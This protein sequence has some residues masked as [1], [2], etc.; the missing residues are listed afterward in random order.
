MPKC[1]IILKDKK[2][3]PPPAALTEPH[4]RKETAMHWNTALSP[5]DKPREG[6]VYAVVEAFGKIF[7]LRYGYYDDKD[8]TGPPDVIYPDFLK[9]PSY[10]ESG[11]PLVTRMQDACPSYKGEARRADDAVCPLWI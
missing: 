3:H 1:D 8:R 10:T 4:G 6:D 5:P 11:E 2:L 7:E 9:A